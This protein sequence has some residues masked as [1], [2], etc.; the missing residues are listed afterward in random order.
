[1]ELKASWSLL[2]RG[3]RSS[4][5]RFPMASFSRRAPSTQR[6]PRANASRANYIGNVSLTARCSHSGYSEVLSSAS[7][8]NTGFYSHLEYLSGYRLCN[9]HQYHFVFLERV[10]W[11]SSQSKRTENSEN[12][13]SSTQTPSGWGRRHPIETGE[14]RP[15][16]CRIQSLIGSFSCPSTGLTLWLDV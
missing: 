1:M 8:N 7:S 10:N 3:I 2:I 12:K 13:T 6:R 5:P 9:S 16:V 4:M 11:I 15:L 14:R